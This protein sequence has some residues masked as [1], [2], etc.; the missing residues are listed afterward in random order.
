VSRDKNVNGQMQ[1][2]ARTLGM[3]VSGWRETNGALPKKLDSLRVLN[4][5]SRANQTTS[6]QTK[7][8][9]PALS[10]NVA[11]RPGNRKWTSAGIAVAVHFQMPGLRSSSFA[12]SS[13]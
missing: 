8:C 4:V 12:E 6:D 9:P 1:W 7:Q 3:E 10:A 2:R 11:A 5:G 13:R